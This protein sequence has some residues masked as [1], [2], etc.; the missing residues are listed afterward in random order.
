MNLTWL[1]EFR[2]PYL[3]K[4]VGKGVFLSG[5]TLGMIAS[6]QNGK[7][8]KINDAPLFKKLSFGKLQKRDLKKQLAE[9]PML[10]R[11]YEIPYPRE[12]IE[13]AQTASELLL[14]GPE[15]LGVDGNFLFSTGFL[16]AWKYFY[17]TYESLGSQKTA[18]EKMNEEA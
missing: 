2:D 12:L 7:G 4:D 1:D 17:K 14:S 16:N 5:I 11:A 9:L 13:L 3:Q 10:L 8:S 6:C 18:S 15:E